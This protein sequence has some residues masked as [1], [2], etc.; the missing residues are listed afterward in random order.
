MEARVVPALHGLLWVAHGFTLFRAHPAAWLVLFPLLW[1]ALFALVLVPLIGPLV[2]LALMPGFTAGMM[3]AAAESQHG[4]AP[5]PQALFVPLRERPGDHLKLGLAYTAAVFGSFFLLVWLLP[6][7]PRPGDLAKGGRSLTDFAPFLGA[8]A[9]VYLPIMMALWFS[10][11]LVHWH[12][13][14][15]GKALFFSLVAGLRNWRAFA[16]YGVA[17]LLLQLALPGL[18]S[19]LLNLVLPAGKASEF[20]LAVIFVPYGLVVA[21]TFA[22]SYY[23]SFVA[24]LPER[25][26]PPADPA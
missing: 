18:V 24:I 15:P 6:S 16:V 3:Y 22:C 13:M 10:P 11:A 2:A 26:P 7:A 8:A 21:C 25:S 5:L 23:S 17:F 4:R 20:I 9:L 12:R 19:R 1:L 14:K